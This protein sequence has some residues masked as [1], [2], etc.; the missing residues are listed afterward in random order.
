MIVSFIG[1]AE[2]HYTRDDAVKLTETLETYVNGKDVTFY[3]GLDGRFDWMAKN[4]CTEY[5]KKHGNASVVF[6]TP[7]IDEPYLRNLK[8][9]IKEFDDILYPGLERIP[10]RFAISARNKYMIDNSDL[11]ICYVR[12]LIGNANKCW[13]YADGKGV[14][15][16]NLFAL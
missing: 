5:K 7:Y 9:A 16:V 6:V 8:Y 11:L 12:N 3:M 2:E 10:K 4:C 1:H 15:T 14:K 13:K